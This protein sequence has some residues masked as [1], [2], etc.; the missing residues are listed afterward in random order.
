VSTRSKEGLLET[1]RYSGQ[2]G[3][4][5]APESFRGWWLE[6]RALSST[7]ENPEVPGLRNFASR[8]RKF[9]HGLMTLRTKRR[10]I[11]PGSSGVC[12]ASS[13]SR[14]VRYRAHGGG[15]P[16]GFARLSC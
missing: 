11:S 9:P 10:W 5:P 14:F 13:T 12:F 3:A 16:C 7:D 15:R 1:R 4:R 8:C 2:T 6:K